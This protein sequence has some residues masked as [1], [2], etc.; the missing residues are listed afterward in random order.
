MSAV[1]TDDASTWEVRD[2]VRTDIQAFT[3]VA[4]G[5]GDPDVLVVTGTGN[6][7]SVDGG[8]SVAGLGD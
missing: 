5:T 3:W 2:E 8:R 6:L 4:S 1:P 7:H